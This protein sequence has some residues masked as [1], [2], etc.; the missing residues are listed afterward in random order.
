MYCGKC[1][2]KNI[3]GAMYCARCGEKLSNGK[4]VLEESFGTEVSDNDKNRKVGIIV[5]AVALLACFVLVFSIFG[6]RSYKS[7]V[8]KYINAQFDGDVKTIVK[9]IPKKIMNDTLEETGYKK[10]E[11]IDEIEEEIQEQIDYLDEYLGDKWKVSYEIVETEDV[12]GEDFR[13]LRE[14]YEEMDLKISAAKE[15][16]V[17]FTLK[18]HDT[19]MSDSLY[20]S[21]VKIGRS[22]YLDVENMGGLL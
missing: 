16:E 2:A 1:G 19:E 20:I 5:V 11:L 3:D 22:W 7:T 21:L 13:D 4:V 9:L 12:K 17:E 18:A 6:G 14:D 15:V 8:K 10:G